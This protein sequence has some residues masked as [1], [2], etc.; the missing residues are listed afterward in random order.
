MTFSPTA[1]GSVTGGLTVTSSASNSTLTVGLSGTGVTAGQLA[2]NPTSLS[3]GNVQV[4]ANQ[5]LTETLKNSGSENLTISQATFTGAGF[6]YTGLSLPLM[7]TPNQSTTFGVVFTPSTA[8]AANEILSI[9][10]SGSSTTL[11]IALSGIGVLPATLVATPASL[12]FTNV[13]VGQNQSHTE[14][15][16]NTGGSNATISQASV[17]GTGFSISGFSTPVTAGTGTK[18]V[19]QRDLCAAVCGQCQWK[20]G[21]CFECLESHLEHNAERRAAPA[22][23][24]LCG[25]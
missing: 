12:T 1:S 10:I 22:T 23:R 8:G 20:C 3:L 17:A 6:S 24:F 21:D 18:R 25:A 14:T 19:F 16:N 11:D 4:G 7:L 2:A 5:T 15:V 13:V 9:T